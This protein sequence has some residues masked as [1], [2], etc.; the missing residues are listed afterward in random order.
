MV[1]LC[2]CTFYSQRI[3]SEDGFLLCDHINVSMT[4]V[5]QESQA[6]LFND[7]T[8]FHNRGGCVQSVD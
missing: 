3:A 5:Y 8:T 2:P 7:E 1:T 6:G 4:A